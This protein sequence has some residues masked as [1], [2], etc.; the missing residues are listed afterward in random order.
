MASSR[1]DGILPDATEPVGRAFGVCSLKSPLVPVNPCMRLVPALHDPAELIS[2]HD[3]SQLPSSAYV[4]LLAFIQSCQQLA[5]FLRLSCSLFDTNL[6]AAPHTIRLDLLLCT[7]P[8]CMCLCGRK[9]RCINRLSSRRCRVTACDCLRSVTAPLESE[10]HL[11]PLTQRR[12]IGIY[13]AC[14]GRT[15]G[16]TSRARAERHRRHC[17]IHQR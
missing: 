17:G 14:T 8:G 16:K 3:R 10:H 15:S 12:K 5:F 2:S 4:L 11:S 13:H 1:R 9:Q 7:G 6:I